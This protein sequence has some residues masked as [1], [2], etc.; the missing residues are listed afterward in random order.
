MWIILNLDPEIYDTKVL[1]SVQCFIPY[2]FVPYL[3]PYAKLVASKYVLVVSVIK[4]T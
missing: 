4:K 3:Y 2:H 1:T